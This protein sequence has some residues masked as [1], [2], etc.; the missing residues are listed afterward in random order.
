MNPKK[1]DNSILKLDGTTLRI[2]DVVEVAR[3]EKPVGLADAAR[4]NV[5]QSRKTLEE[6]ADSPQPIYGINTGFGRLVSQRIST[7]ERRQLQ[8]NLILSHSAG[9]GRPLPQEVVRA[10]IL[11]RVNSLAKGYSGIRLNT[12]YTLIEF[13][14]RKIHPHVPQ[15]GSV[16]ASGDL[17]PSAHIAAVLLGKG[18]AYFADELVPGDVAMERADLKPIRL[19]AKE[20]LAL[21][22]G[23][24]VMCA[25]LC[26]A[27]ADCEHLLKMADVIAALSTVVLNGN[28]EQFAPEIQR[29]RP[30][31]GQIA[32]ADNLFRL[33]NGRGSGVHKTPQDAYS[34]RCVPQVH[35]AIRTAL[36]HTRQVLETEINSATD[37]PLVFPEKN[38]ILSGGNFHGEPVAL[39]GDYLKLGIAELGN[40]SERRTNRLLNPDLNG[41][42]PPFLA[43][44][45]GLNSGFMLAQ[46]TAASLA[47]ENKVLV[48]PSTVDSIPVSADQE[49]HVSMGMNAALHLRKVVK[50]VETILGIELLCACQG[51]EF[52]EAPVPE[53]LS[54]AYQTVRNSVPA[55]EE[56]AETYKYI[57]K[58]VT[59]VRD[60]HLLDEVER[61]IG[62]LG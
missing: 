19:A 35:G 22:N 6:L 32:S 33:L 57:E 26:L 24:P 49:D 13:L 16:G 53:A 27:V 59:L 30:H 60:R 14:N 37:N 21:I 51:M 54:T 43:R 9:M 15:T 61:V 39:V 34:I 4:A 12:L 41:N 36:G 42:L 46:Y 20:G 52:Q 62:R 8:E 3:H 48:H 50:N 47:S 10:A 25:L 44:D 7:D 58:A 29:A 40:I 28:V 18:R 5:R 55:L 38:E 23:T 31:P 45:A 17:A 1:E 56:D 11:L 2:E